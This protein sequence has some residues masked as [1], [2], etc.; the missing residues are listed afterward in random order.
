MFR[1]CGWHEQFLL[2][3]QLNTTTTLP[4]STETHGLGV[5]IIKKKEKKKYRDRGRKGTKKG[6]LT[7]KEEDWEN[8]GI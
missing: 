8:T 4:A 5:K 3:N 7:L 2:P 1:K 6:M